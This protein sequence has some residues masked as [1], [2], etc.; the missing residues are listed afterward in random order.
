MVKP[1]R[2]GQPGARHFSQPGAFAAEHIFHLAVAVGG[3][4]AE[5]INVLA[6]LYLLMNRD[7]TISEKSAMVENS[8]SMVCSSVSRL[9]RTAGSGAFTRT[10]SKKRSTLR[11]KRRDLLRAC[12][13]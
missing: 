5:R 3:A 11:A 2:H 1:G 7:V 9:W 13:R 6:H 12:S 8:A 10:L 4:A